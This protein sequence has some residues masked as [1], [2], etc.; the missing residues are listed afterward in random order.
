MLTTWN[1]S[2]RI[3]NILIQHF[4][5][6]CQISCGKDKSAWAC[7]LSTKHMVRTVPQRQTIGCDVVRSG[8]RSLLIGILSALKFAKLAEALKIAEYS[9]MTLGFT[10]C[11]FK[12]HWEDANLTKLMRMIKAIHCEP[13]LAEYQND[14]C[15]Q[16]YNSSERSTSKTVMR[17]IGF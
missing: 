13:S 2:N 9:S 16:T 1:V 17:F 7:C 11:Q 3:E 6:C 14:A 4:V 15:V 5:Q 12:L 10:V 8:G